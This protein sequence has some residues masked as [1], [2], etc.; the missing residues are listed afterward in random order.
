MWPAV[1]LLDHCDI[2]LGFE[3]LITSLLLASSLNT[4]YKCMGFE[5]IY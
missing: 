2:L 4:E 5:P 1:E 3:Y